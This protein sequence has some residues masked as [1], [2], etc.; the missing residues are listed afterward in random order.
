MVRRISSYDLILFYFLIFCRHEKE[1]FCSFDFGISRMEN[2][3]SL[4]LGDPKGDDQRWWHDV[5][6]QVKSSQLEQVSLILP[7]KPFEGLPRMNFSLMDWEKLDEQLVRLKQ[8]S[9]RLEVVL[10]L[11]VGFER[12]DGKADCERKLSELRASTFG[13]SLLPRSDSAGIKITTTAVAYNPD[14]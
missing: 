1:Q 10:D 7:C 5:L 11:T 12:H 4:R 14:L 3:V 6:D 8:A 2:L 13:I 9:S